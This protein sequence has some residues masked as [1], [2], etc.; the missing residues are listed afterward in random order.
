MRRLIDFY[1]LQIHVMRTWRPSTGSRLRRLL[2]T[3]LVSVLSF[4]IAVYLTPGV[5]LTAGAGIFS[6]AL[7]A[8]IVLGILNVAIR[9]VL[10]AAFAAVSVIAV[11]IATLV[12]QVVSFLILPRF[13]DT[14]VVS[15]WFAALVASLIYAMAT[16]VFV[17]IFS[18]SSDDSY[19]AILVQ[20][21]SARGQDV[22]RTDA[23]G[24]VVV[25]IDGLAR[26]IL[27][28]QIQAGRAPHLSGWVRSGRYTLSGWEALLPPTTPAS[29]AGLLHGNNDGIPAFRWYE[30]DAGRLMVTNHPD[31]AVVVE[32]RISNGEGL[33]SNDGASVGNL[34]SGDAARSYITMATIKDKSQ[35]LGKSTSFYSFFASPNNYLGTLTRFGAEVVKEYYQASRQVRGD[36]I[37]R[38]HRGMPYPFARATTNVGLRDLSTA[39]VVEEMY[40]GAPIIYVDFT[41]YDEIAHHSGPERGESLDALDGVDGAIATLEKAAGG[42]P[43]PY[44]F[45]VLSDHGQTLGATFLQRYGKTLG[46]VVQGLMGSEA[47]VQE[48]TSSGEEFGQTNAF[49]SELTQVKGVTGGIAR[50][51]LRS[52]TTDGVVDVGSTTPAGADA[53]KSSDTIRVARARGSSRPGRGGIGQSRADL[54]PAPARSSDARAARDDLSPPRRWAGSAPGCRG[55]ADPV[56]GARRA[57]H[58][59]IGHQLPGRGA[60]RGRR[61]GRPVRR[62]VARGAHPSRLPPALPG[63]LR[64][65]PVRP[66]IRGGRG[67]RGADRLT[68]RPRRGPD[69]AAPP[70][71]DGVDPGRGARRSTSRPPPDPP[72]GGALPGPPLRQGR[73][74][75]APADAWPG[76]P[77]ESR[78]PA[79][80]RIDLPDRTAECPAP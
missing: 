16:T 41:D 9:P 38:M 77:R 52:Q 80:L 65:Q 45:I 36:I 34:F 15:G 55:P 66:G 69:T 46:D 73:D 8:A 60:D 19:F 39:L 4:G 49:L 42:A 22:H 30:K 10:I 68:R 64:D 6:T 11:T 57:G 17:A 43:R 32:S 72:L 37:P 47:T 35:G 67:L 61:S 54:L 56:G 23:P 1:R 5:D 26:Q 20:Q 31:D 28:R 24:L 48:D 12:F 58:R 3:M 44:R 21:L 71:S 70:A 2:A 51:A 63:H 79:E 59:A 53:D 27:T 40:R 33:L 13:V 18:I 7:L 62:S 29:Q 50:T 75:T 78:G 14:L 76:H 74:G 25:Q